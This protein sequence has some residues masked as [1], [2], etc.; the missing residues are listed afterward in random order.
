MNSIRNLAHD[1][2]LTFLSADKNLGTVAVDTNW[3][4][5]EAAAMLA[6]TSTYSLVDRVNFEQTVTNI[7]TSITK[8]VT[9]TF[10]LLHLSDQMIK[11]IRSQ[12]T[13]SST[14]VPVFYLLIKVHKPT[15]SGRPIVPGVRWITTP[16]SVVLDHLL[17]PTLSFIPWLV[18]DTKSLVTDLERRPQLNKGGVLISADITSLYTNINTTR[19]IALVREFLYEFLSGSW[20]F[21][22]LSMVLQL[23]TIVMNNNY[24]QF[25][26]NIYH[27][28]NGTAMGTNVAPAYANIVVF[29]LERSF[30][31]GNA[32][33][34]LYYRLLD[35]V[36]LYV[37]QESDVAAVTTTMNSWDTSI[38]FTFNIHPSSIPFLDLELFKG[39]RFLS[40]GVFDM[41]LY[42]KA[43]NKY[44]YIPYKSFHT[45]PMKH[46][47][48]YTELIR[49]IRN[50]NNIEDYVRVKWEFYK[51]LRE[52]GYPPY[53][54]LPTF[55]SIYYE[56]RALLL[57]PASTPL[58]TLP[59]PPLSAFLIKRASREQKAALSC[60][61]STKSSRLVFVTHYSPLSHVLS[62]RNI[63]MD[64]WPLIR[65]EFPLIRQPMIAYKSHNTLGALLKHKHNNNNTIILDEKWGVLP[66]PAIKPKKAKPI[67][68]P[69]ILRFFAPLQNDARD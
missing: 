40:S 61:T 23:L 42:Q 69:S 24:L 52:R 49:Y 27:Q 37:A 68:T 29:M 57:L 4:H 12:V 25:N 58:S 66:K 9:S 20:V 51:R 10:G 55:T 56:D 43:M 32:S 53:F 2:S 46:S 15:L 33:I 31:I 50:N 67:A 65:D 63:L 54:L 19:G 21:S 6:D 44:L 36:F 13:P 8:L 45:A 14:S 7:Y 1:S 60:T 62:I 17:T 22:K 16:T 35:D 48:I 39:P 18:R 5:Q 28:H 64:K 26:G 59:Q 41:R 3:Y 34:S 38:Q 30:V 11:F 47:F